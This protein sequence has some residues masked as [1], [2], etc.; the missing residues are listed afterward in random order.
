VPRLPPL[1]EVTGTPIDIDSKPFPAVA[2]SLVCYHTLTTYLWLLNQS[3][4]FG[5]GDCQ[6]AA[7]STLA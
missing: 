5:L 1:Y 3:S 4:A 7:P 2:H 6:R